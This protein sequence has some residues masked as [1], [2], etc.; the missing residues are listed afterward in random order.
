ML[1]SLSWVLSGDVLAR[2]AVLA[3]TFVAVRALTP[4]LFGL[5]IVLYALA[6]VAA[7]VWD[8]GVSV[9]VSRE[10]G[11]G[12]ATQFGALADGCRLRLAALPAWGAAIV[13]GLVLVRGFP[14]LSLPVCIMFLVAS[15]SAG[16]S[17][18]SL[19]ALRG[20]HRFVSS[21]SAQVLGKCTTAV[22]SGVAL[23]LAGP[24]D[25]LLAL[26][27]AF[28]AGEV[29]TL[30][31]SIALILAA[32]TGMV[33]KAAES[34][35]LR[36]S[37]PF[38]ANAAMSI[39]YNRFDVVLVGILASASA[40]GLYGA[41]SRTQD[42]LY[43]IPAAVGVVAL[44][45]ISRCAA[46]GG[47][48]AARQLVRRFW[49]LG[50]GVALPVTVAI[51]LAAPTLV[52]WVLGSDY[53]A[54]VTPVRI[55]IWF[56]PLAVIQAPILAG[57]AGIGAGKLTTVIVLTAL[58]SALILQLILAPKF[59][60]TGGAFASLGRDVVTTPVAVLLAYLNGLIG[61]RETGPTRSLLLQ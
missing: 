61:S 1:P 10:V 4:A 35:S 41:A 58:F 18:L 40:A 48:G 26:G 34:I 2:V 25:R 15:A 38:A 14:G 5:Y 31:I 32:K 47:L 43:A 33:R 42:A 60:A 39:F 46:D 22:L 12:R 8:L 9:V 36:Q 20:A 44:P 27:A 59:G 11:A 17:T 13:I 6:L 3:T 37:L 52:P 51:F 23:V 53:R 7:V 21:S 16:M 49:I 55:L 28:A 57:L 56:L 45:M 24:H 19:A 29:V 50:L 30:L 54:A